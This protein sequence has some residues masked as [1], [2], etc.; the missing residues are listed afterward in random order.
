[1]KDMYGHVNRTTLRRAALDF[2]LALMLFWLLTF[3]LS[4]HDGRA[5][6]VPL[7]ASPQGVQTPAERVNRLTLLSFESRGSRP[8]P[9][10]ARQSLGLLSLAF[11]LLV[12]LNLAIWRHLRRA[13][14]SPR[15]G[16]WRRG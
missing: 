9:P 1:M 16:V 8:N 10:N 13:Y 14:A 11:A 12:A 3:A 5:H 6:A 4:T 2:A 15:R 7:Y